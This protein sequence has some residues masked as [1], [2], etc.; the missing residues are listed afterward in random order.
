[1]YVSDSLAGLGTPEIGAHPESRIPDSDTAAND[2]VE[3]ARTRAMSIID[4]TMLLVAALLVQTSTAVTNAPT[5]TGLPLL[6]FSA[7]CLALFVMARQAL[8][9]VG[10]P[11]VGAAHFVSVPLLTAAAGAALALM[12]GPLAGS[13]G[14]AALESAR[15]WL[16]ATLYV[17]AGRLAFAWATTGRDLI[18][19]AADAVDQAAKRAFDITASSLLLLLALPVILCVAAAIKLEDGGP[20]FFRCRRIGEGGRELRMLKF[21]KM[22]Q[23]AFGPPLTWSQDDRFTRVGHLLANSKLDE[24]PQLWNVLRGGM[25]LVGPRPEDPAFVA[26]RA[27]EFEA[28]LWIKPGVTGLCQL[29][30]AKEERI[31]DPKDRV[32]DYAERL[33]PQKMVIDE[34]YGRRRT[35]FFDAKILMWTIVAVLLRQDVA[36]H[37]QTGNLTLRR[38]RQV[39][40]PSAV[41]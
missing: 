16:V 11:A 32:R 31:L 22:R 28:I 13:V 36:V 15:P 29:A 12:Q 3:Q 5:T 17:L 34:L 35:F 1:V 33:L 20:I 24:L 37:R 21:R 9:S 41:A 25:S 4:G 2:A 14:T 7:F 19:P 30:F 10:V 6:L 40:S 38:R 39:D 23:D 18:R 8:A 26:M 27:K